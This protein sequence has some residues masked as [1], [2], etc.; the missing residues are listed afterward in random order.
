[1]PIKEVLLHQNNI[2]V[3]LDWIPRH[4]HHYHQSHLFS[5]SIHE[6]NGTNLHASSA[7]RWGTLSFDFDK[8][9]TR[10]FHLLVQFLFSCVIR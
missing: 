3:I 1:M 4:F 5:I 7:S 8:E 10:R 2:G 9:E 6:Y